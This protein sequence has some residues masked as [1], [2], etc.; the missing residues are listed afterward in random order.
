[1]TD[2]FDI[3]KLDLGEHDILVV[4]V[5]GTISD[6]VVSAVRYQAQQVLDTAGLS[7]A[8]AVIDDNISFGVIH[9]EEKIIKTLA[10]MDPAAPSEIDGDLYCFFCGVPLTC[11]TLTCR[12]REGDHEPDCIWMAAKRVSD[13]NLHHGEKPEGSTTD[14]ARAGTG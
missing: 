3:A 11:H 10:E 8:V 7:N 1:M 13:E 4:R 5:K 2:V 12:T 6:Q 9:A 14:P